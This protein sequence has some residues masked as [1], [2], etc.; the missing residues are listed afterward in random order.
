MTILGGDDIAKFVADEEDRISQSLQ[1]P[2]FYTPLAASGSW[3]DS[4]ALAEE[5]SQGFY[6]AVDDLVEELY[7]EDGDEEG[8]P[9]PRTE[10]PSIAHAAVASDALLVVSR[11]MPHTGLTP[12]SSPRGGRWGS[13]TRTGGRSSGPRRTTRPSATSSSAGSGTHAA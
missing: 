11:A 7:R 13:S 2:V 10:L 4:E 12:R 8:E 5:D 1:H 6:T 9:V 3:G